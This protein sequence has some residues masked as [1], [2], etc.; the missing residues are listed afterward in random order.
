MNPVRTLLKP[1]QEYSWSGNT[2]EAIVLH[3]TLGNTYVGAEQ[4]LRTRHLSYHF[5]IDDEGETYQLVDIKRSAW[6]SGVK[7]KPNLRARAFFGDTNPNKRTIGIAFVR[8]RHSEITPAQR[9]AAV[10]LIKWIGEQT[11]IRYN[12][13]NIFTHYEITS[14]KPQE[15]QQYRNQVIEGLEGYKDEKD[16][17]EKATYELLRTILIELIKRLLK[18]Q[19][20]KT[21]L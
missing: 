18:L 19:N 15:V 3:T 12:R 5:I 2:Q 17:G 9:D 4:T 20:E 11:G 10:K 14:Y 7:S 6:H 8:N 21:N 1:V 16:A 13:D